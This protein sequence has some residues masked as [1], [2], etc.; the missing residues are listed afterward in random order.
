MRP[1]IGEQPAIQ[2]LHYP[3]RLLR[4][5]ERPPIVC[6]FGMQKSASH[7]VAEAL[8]AM[9][10]PPYGRMLR[11]P[12]YTVSAQDDL[13]TALRWRAPL[14]GVL[15][16]HALPSKQTQAAAR[17]LDARLV[18]TVRHPADQ[19]TG[20]ACHTR[21]KR[22]TSRGERSDAAVAD[23][24]RGGHLYRWLHWMGEWLRLSKEIHVVR[25][26]DLMTAPE[27]TLT[28]AGEFAFGEVQPE[29]LR[30]ALA[31]LETRRPDHDDPELYPH[32]WTGRVGVWRDY[33][34]PDDTKTYEAVV[35][36]FLECHPSAALIRD[37]YPGIDRLEKR[38]SETAPVSI[39]G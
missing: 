13:R 12:S 23:M 29:R 10:P 16:G 7:R 24:L 30:N 6:V 35:G 9:P 20:V 2:P 1:E 19:I 33:F 25:Y 38:G 36:S 28:A 31:H 27:P 32:G 3:L 18:I 4:P 34:G 15:H 26:E 39:P 14:G 17:A 21:R 37:I 8:G 11:R 22:R 5:F